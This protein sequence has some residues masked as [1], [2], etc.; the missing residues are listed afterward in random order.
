MLHKCTPVSSDDSINA[1]H[2]QISMTW[3]NHYN[4]KP[5]SYS[6]WEKTVTQFFNIWENMREKSY[7]SE[8][9][10]TFKSKFQI[11]YVSAYMTVFLPDSN[12][13]FFYMQH[14]VS[15]SVSSLFSFF[16]F[17]STFLFLISSPQDIFYN[18]LTMFNSI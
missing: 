7:I 5:S 18:L 3:T 16:C 9:F 10:W 17:H 1:S 4:S 8:I 13:C 14:H 6:V 12:N 15:L 2:W 11:I